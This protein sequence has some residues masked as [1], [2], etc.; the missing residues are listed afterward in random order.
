MPRPCSTSSS[1][2]LRRLTSCHV[3]VQLPLIMSYVISRHA[4]SMFYFNP[5]CRMASHFMSRPC[6]TSPHHVV[7]HLTSCHVLVRLPPVMSYVISRHRHV[8]DQL[9][10]VMSQGIPPHAASMLKFHPS[11]PRSCHPMPRPCSPYPRHVVRHIT[12]CHVHRRLTS[13]MSEVASPR[14][15]QGLTTP[16]TSKVDSPRHVQ[17]RVNP[18]TSKVCHVQGRSSLPRP[19]STHLRH[20]EGRHTPATSEV[21][22]P[23]PRP[24][25]HHPRHVQGFTAATSKVDS[26][27]SCPGSHLPQV[28]GHSPPPPC[29]RSPY[30]KVDSS[31][32]CLRSP[33]PRNV[34]FRTTVP[35]PRSTH[36]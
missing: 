22:S 2:V 33:Q 14:H 10:P 16:A 20:V 25:L 30:R 11:S 27:P 1:H 32:L 35:R 6:S 21:D 28:Q 29:P 7:R 19:R 15:V 17:G 23:L 8:R 4:T 18:A 31:L 5:P 24:R 26:A 9:P 12:P 36:P 3:H 13:T 34:R